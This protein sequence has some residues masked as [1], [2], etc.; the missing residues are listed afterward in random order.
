MQVELN[1]FTY[2]DS[3]D[4]HGNTPRWSYERSFDLKLTL[5]HSETA[6]RR[7]GSRTSGSYESLAT[8]SRNDT[9]TP[10]NHD[11]IREMLIDIDRGRMKM[12]EP[13]ENMMS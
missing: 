12:I 13:K 11:G 6:R 4:R 10:S 2:I 7:R 5:V 3:L 9:T 8:S 1:C